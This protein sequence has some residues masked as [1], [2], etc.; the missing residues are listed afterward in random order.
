MANCGNEL[1][2]SPGGDTF[3]DAYIKIDEIGGYISNG[4][5]IAGYQLIL[6]KCNATQLTVTLPSAGDR[7]ISGLGVTI[8]GPG[9]F[10]A[11][12]AAGTWQIGG[13]NYTNAAP[14]VEPLVAADPALDR[15]DIVV[16]GNANNDVDVITG[17]A[18]DTPVAP[19]PGANE[20][21][22]AV[23]SIPAAGTPIVIPTLSLPAG[24]SFAQ[25]L[26]WDTTTGKWVIN[27][28]LKSFVD[29]VDPTQSGTVIQ[30]TPVGLSLQGANFNGGAFPD[31][32]IFAQ[33]ETGPT[34]ASQ[35]RM[36]LDATRSRL[37]FIPNST[38]G[39]G[40]RIEA[41]ATEMRIESQS[42]GSTILLSAEEGIEIADNGTPTITTEKLYNDAGALYWNGLEICLSPCGGGGYVI[43]NTNIN[44]AGTTNLPNP[45]TENEH[46]VKVFTAGSVTVNL[47]VAPTP[48]YKVTVKDALGTAATDE[49]I[50]GPGGGLIDNSGATVQIN[51][52]HGSLTFQY[53][54]DGLGSTWCII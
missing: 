50:I 14:Y 38:L 3:L 25:T 19:T 39:I 16:V 36:A 30:S 31:V 7:I 1:D 11:N 37:E 13:N 41:N 51:Q 44:A 24:T 17:I 15:L 35:A 27:N 34:T 26:R 21:L 43:A 49:I 10:N 29:L 12:V 6:T 42:A 18:A 33:V 9:P 28:A 23:I 53:I 40:Q 46:F 54:D 52:N 20:L 47:P 8:T 2:Y 4:L 22:V 5:S 32:S 45:T 48:N